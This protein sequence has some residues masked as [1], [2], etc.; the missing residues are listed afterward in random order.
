[1]SSMLDTGT[2][3]RRRTAQ[4]ATW[5]NRRVAA[6]LVLAAWASL[7]WFLLLSDRVGLYLSTRTSWVVPMAAVTLSVATASLLV[8]ARGGRREALHVDEAIWMTVLV[9]PVVLLL[10]LPP[11]TLGSFSATR[12]SQ[13]AGSSLASVSSGLDETGEVTLLTLAVAKTSVAGSELLVKRG[14]AEVDFVGIVARDSSM[15]PDELLLTR[16]VVTCC[17]AD[18][19]V[20]QVRVVNVTPGLF[21]SDDW[22]EVRGRVYAIGREVIVDAASVEEVAPPERPYLS[23]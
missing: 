20:V 12:K 7:F 5:S 4:T 10:A 16:Y 2:T 19:T 1:M 15:P 21:E 18:A 8:A 11:T 13:F 17:V 9:M 6:A 23:P 3:A 14:G 22:I